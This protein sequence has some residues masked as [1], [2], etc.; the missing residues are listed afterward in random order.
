[1]ERGSRDAGSTGGHDTMDVL[2]FAGLAQALGGARL[3]LAAPW[4]TT[5]AELRVRLAREWPELARA[6][7]RTAVNQRYV[8]DGEPLK[9][10]DEIALIPPVSGG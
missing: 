3:T 9:P 5:V 8:S 10:G 4:P 6:T 1:M 2:L 7:F